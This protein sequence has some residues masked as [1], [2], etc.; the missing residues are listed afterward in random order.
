MKTVVLIAIFSYIAFM[1]GL[2]IAPSPTIKP[3]QY[4]VFEDGTLVMVM[5]DNSQVVQ[6]LPKQLCKEER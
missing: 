5:S 3:I 2:C 6:C 4:T 1:V